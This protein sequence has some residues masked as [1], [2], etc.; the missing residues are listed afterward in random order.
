MPLSFDEANTIKTLGIQWHPGR[1]I[2]KFKINLQDSQRT[3]KRTILSDIARLYDPLGWISP[4]VIVGK[5]LMQEIWKEN[6]MWDSEL[7]P[8]IITKWHTLKME[9]KALNHIEI[10]R[11]INITKDSPVEIHGF[12]DASEKAYAAAVYV[13]ASEENRCHTHLLLAKTRV[14]PLKNKSLA[15]LELCG[16]V[17]LAHLL[18]HIME[19]MQFKDA[20]IFAWSDSQITLSWIKSAPHIRTTFVANRV[21]EIQELTDP[22][23]WNYVPSKDNPADVASRGLSPK[24][25]LKHHQ[26][27]YGPEL[28]FQS[29]KSK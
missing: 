6:Q 4:C 22:R 17:L 11:W 7:P 26:W 3:T 21:A 12:C 10:P 13:R 23:S 15:R 9:L 16:A 8:T 20:K 5:I 18:E 29:Q 14:A 24:D 28:I 1:D 19:T 27:W 25:L 2:F